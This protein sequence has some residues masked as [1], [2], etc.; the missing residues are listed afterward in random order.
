A[1]ASPAGLDNI[2]SA[3]VELFKGVARANVVM[4]G[5]ENVSFASKAA[6]TAEV[7]VLRA[8][9]Y[10]LLADLFGGV[11][12]VTEPEI[13]ARPQNTRAEVFAFVESELKAARPDLPAKW[14]ADMNGRFTQGAV[15]AILASLYLNARVF[16]GDVSATGL[17]PGAQRWQDAVTAAN[18]VI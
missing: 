18:A 9:Y 13:A 5:I 4:K 8:F 2:N 1:P 7:R 10:F 3:W 6:G 12:I 15:D 17:T 11:P 16:T 14:S